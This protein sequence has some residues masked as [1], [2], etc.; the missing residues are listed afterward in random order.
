[1]ATSVFILAAGRRLCDA[2][3]DF[4][5]LHEPLMSGGNMDP[6]AVYHE[7]GLADVDGRVM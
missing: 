7:V 2:V 6:R 4:R 1:M 5:N 3:N